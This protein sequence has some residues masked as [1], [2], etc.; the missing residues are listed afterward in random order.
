[1]SINVLHLM[2]EWTD[3]ISVVDEEIAPTA[4]VANAENHR[5]SAV[6]LKARDAPFAK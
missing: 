4:L 1:M 5:I 2:R 6:A 3:A